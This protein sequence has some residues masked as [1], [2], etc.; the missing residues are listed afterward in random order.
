MVTGADQA[1]FLPALFD[2]LFK[3]SAWDTGVPA[4]TK[5]FWYQYADT[6]LSLSE[7]ECQGWPHGAGG[8]ERIVDWWY[9]LYSGIDH[10]RNLVEPTPNLSAC[11]Y[12]AYPDAAALQAC[13][14]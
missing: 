4:V 3:E 11:T 6:G 2:I 5:I 14:P 13:E 8:P 7:V 12:R 1:A 9:G 10:T